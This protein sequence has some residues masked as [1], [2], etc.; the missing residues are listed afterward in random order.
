LGKFGNPQTWENLIQ[1]TE[2]E[3]CDP[4]IFRLARMLRVR[5]SL[6]KEKRLFIPVYPELVAHKQ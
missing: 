4:Y 1:M 3:I 5:A 6:S 2:I